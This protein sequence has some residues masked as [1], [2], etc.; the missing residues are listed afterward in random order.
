MP[1]LT[2]TLSFPNP[3]NHYLEVEILW[4]NFPQPKSGFFDLKIP[5]WTPGSYLIREYARNIEGFKAFDEDDNALKYRKINKNTWRVILDCSQKTLKI[6]YRIYCFEV[7]VRNNFLDADHAL[8]VGANTFMYFEGWQDQDA[9]LIVK[10]PQIWQNIITA[11]PLISEN[12]YYI[13]DY[14]TLIDAPLGLGNAQVHT[15]EIGEIPHVHAFLGIEASYQ[16]SSEQLIKDTKKIAKAAQEVFGENPCERYVFLTYL[17]EESR[18]GL[19]HKDST[20]L[21]FPRLD[22]QKEEGYKEYLSL[23]G[24]EY[25]HLWNV[26]R[27]RPTPLGPF[28]YEKENYT[29]LLWQVEGFTS[30]YEKIILLKAGIINEEEYLATLSKKINQI[31]SQEGLKVQSLSEAS[32]DAWIKAYR[33][34]E[35]SANAT[36]SYYTKGAVIALLLDALIITNS[37]G[38]HS[39]DTLMSNLY[40]RYYKE[41]DK[42]FTEEELKSALENLTNSSL[43]TFFEQYIYGVEALS[44]NHFLAPLGL[45][46]EEAPTEKPI[47]PQ[48]GIQLQKN[49]IKMVK[50]NSPAERDGLNVGDKLLAIDGYVPRNFNKHLQKIQIN[51]LINF[52][53]NRAGILKNIQVKIDALAPSVWQLSPLKTLSAEQKKYQQV[54]FRKNLH[55]A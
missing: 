21:H 48:I 3:A 50:M 43:D 1:Q 39:L 20:V 6:K 29:T 15:F 32:W 46:L 26:K 45:Q 12:N 27:L 35:N 51:Q 22:F 33:P 10:P 49:E 2:Y 55:Q 7:S 28:D 44:Y 38:K 16:F 41:L 9:H 54:F 14:D 31:E 36:I 30:Y 23:L 37:E 18:G 11:L 34:N 47:I 17:L 52:T 19:E 5:V 25:F 8:I 42:P 4:Q 24:H 40:Q 13:P 53:L